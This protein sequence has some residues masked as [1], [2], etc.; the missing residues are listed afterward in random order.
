[1]MAQDVYEPAT[2]RVSTW[3]KDM[4]VIEAFARELGCETPCFSATR[5]VYDEAMRQGLGDQDTAAVCRVLEDKAGFT[6]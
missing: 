6:R 1:M 2:M 5:P 4:A 3:Q